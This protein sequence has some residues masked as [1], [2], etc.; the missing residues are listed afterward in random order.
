MDALDIAGDVGPEPEPGSCS[1]G[2]GGSITYLSL[3]G[4][5]L[6]LGGEVRRDRSALIC[7]GIDASLRNVFFERKMDVFLK[8]WLNRSPDCAQTWFLKS[9]QHRLSHTHP[10]CPL[11]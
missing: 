6:V 11:Q 10:F 7:D 5:G 1:A 8:I 3:D 2:V 9:D 4:D